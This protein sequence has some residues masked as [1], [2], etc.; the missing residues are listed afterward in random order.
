MN[1]WNRIKHIP[2]AYPDIYDPER[3]ADVIL[4]KAEELFYEYV[5]EGHKSCPLLW[6]ERKWL[7]FFKEKVEDALPLLKYNT[8]MNL[9]PDYFN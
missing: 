1:Y 8:Y 6:S 2:V 4:D 9:P 3:R 5:M 7:E